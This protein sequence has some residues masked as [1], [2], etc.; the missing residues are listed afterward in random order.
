MSHDDT[1]QQFARELLESVEVRESVKRRLIA[2][3]LPEDVEVM[4]WRIVL[5]GPV[6]TPVT[7]PTRPTL[8]FRRP[9]SDDEIT[10]RRDAAVLAGDVE[11]VERLTQEQENR[12]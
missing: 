4:L 11:T 3:T 6:D 10:A 1:L 5:Y 12:S 9:L 7:I 2:G 8:I